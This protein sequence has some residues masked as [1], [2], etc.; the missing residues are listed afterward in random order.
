MS[1][2]LAQIEIHHRRACPYTHQQM[3]AV[4]R[5]YKQ[6]VKVSLSLLSH[7]QLP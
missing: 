1:T 7:S 2:L 4:E 5:C 3:G 6:I